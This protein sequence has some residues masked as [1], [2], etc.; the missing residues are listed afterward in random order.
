[1]WQF[2]VSPPKRRKKIGTVYFKCE[3]L[4]KWAPLRIWYLWV[5][6]VV[7][8]FLSSFDGIVPLRP[9][10]KGVLTDILFWNIAQNFIGISVIWVV[11]G[12]VI[13]RR[14]LWVSGNFKNFFLFC[15]SESVCLCVCVL[16]TQPKW[17][18]IYGTCM[19][20]LDQAWHLGR[21]NVSISSAS[22]ST[23]SSSSL[24]PP[25]S[26]SLSS[27]LLP[28]L[29]CVCHSERHYYLLLLFVFFSSHLMAC[30]T[31]FFLSIFYS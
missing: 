1:M 14:I 18:V 29:E 23:S 13:K 6:V 4:C 10:A 7:E 21:L 24:P 11:L 12:V 25:S 20:H 27:W 28:L 19:T 30:V 16:V 2:L 9:L 17:H 26:S 22:I 8:R 3:F 15:S 31:H 5:M